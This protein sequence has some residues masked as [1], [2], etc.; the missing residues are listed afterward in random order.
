MVTFIYNC[1]YDTS[2]NK[3]DT[4]KKTFVRVTFT[5]QQLEIFILWGNES[6]ENAILTIP[7]TTINEPP[8][9]IAYMGPASWTY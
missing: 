4:I 1:R 7:K 9:A 2:E 6:L 5:T 3:I 8:N